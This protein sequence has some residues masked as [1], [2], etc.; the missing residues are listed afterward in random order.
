MKPVKTS[1]ISTYYTRKK[2][3][4]NSVHL[5]PSDYELLCSHAFIG[6]CKVVQL[7]STRISLVPGEGEGEAPFWC[8]AAGIGLSDELV[9][10]VTDLS[11]YSTSFDEV[12]F[13]DTHPTLTFYPTYESEWS[14]YHAN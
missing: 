13:G 10:L 8:A 14:D 7:L 9:K 11:G 4:L 5:K 6:D 12:E 2:V 1:K 3:M